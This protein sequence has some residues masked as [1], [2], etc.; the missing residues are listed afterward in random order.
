MDGE[1]ESNLVLVLGA[2]LAALSSGNA[3]PIARILHPDVAWDGPHP[4]QSCRGRD[5][6]VGFLSRGISRQRRITSLR[7]YESGDDVVA[8]AE[9]PDFVD[10]GPNGEETPRSSATLTLTVRDGLVVRLKGS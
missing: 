5:E 8:T 2:W 3:E 4:W 1:P 10:I 7:A 6:A 9:G